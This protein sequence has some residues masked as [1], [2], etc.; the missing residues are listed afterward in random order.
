M[1]KYL[2][3]IGIIFSLSIMPAFAQDGAE[4]VV[5]EIVVTGFDNIPAAQLV[6][7]SLTTIDRFQGDIAERAAKIIIGRLDK[8]VIGQGQTIKQPYKIIRRN[9]A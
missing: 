3:S 5:E 1:N 9:S 4:R 8:Q 6:S 2:L 7:P